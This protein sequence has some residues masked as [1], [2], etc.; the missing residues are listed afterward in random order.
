M[1]FFINV[2]E[3]GPQKKTTCEIYYD[4]LT[5]DAKCEKRKCRDAYRSCENERWDHP[6]SSFGYAKCDEWKNSWFNKAN[7][8]TFLKNHYQLDMRCFQKKTCM[9]KLKKDPCNVRRWC[10]MY[11]EDTDAAVCYLAEAYCP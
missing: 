2:V 1:H 3:G 8:L 6:C 11:R 7:D 9:E 4:R 5:M 10:L